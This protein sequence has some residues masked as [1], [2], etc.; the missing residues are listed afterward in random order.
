MLLR[1]LARRIDQT[2]TFIVVG[3]FVGFLTVQL[4]S[5]PF[6]HLPAGVQFVVTIGFL[7][8]CLSSTFRPINVETMESLPK[9]LG[10]FISY[11]PVT[12]LWVYHP[13]PIFST[14]YKLIVLLARRIQSLS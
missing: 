14:L 11:G 3:A 4:L 6:L 2:I 12:Y 9:T 13:L 7:F 10:T 1:I 5:L 8:Y